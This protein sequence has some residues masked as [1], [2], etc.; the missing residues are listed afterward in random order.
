[1]KK[2]TLKLLV[3]ICITA[4]SASAKE[5][6]SVRHRQGNPTPQVGTCP[7]TTAQTDLDINN[8]RAHILNG[9]DMWW[10]PISQVNTYEVPK[11]SGKNSIYSG[12][13]WIG[14]YDGTGALKVA[15]Q[16]YRQAGGNDFWSGPISK[17][18]VTDSLSITNARCAQFDRLWKLTKVDVQ[19]FIGGGSP[20][21][22]M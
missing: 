4:L 21:Q 13:I 19:N 7:N 12:A 3:L 11:G 17:D 9:G 6:K 20:T 14:G 15:A 16:T 1:M 10:D 8:V 18:T 22:K 5:N 2:S